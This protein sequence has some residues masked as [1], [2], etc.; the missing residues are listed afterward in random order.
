MK[1]ELNDG[2]RW[3]SEAETEKNKQFLFFLIFFFRFSPRPS[4]FLF[5][6][7]S[8]CFYFFPLFF[9]PRSAPEATPPPRARPKKE[10]K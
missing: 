1:F 5:N 9:L 4:I 7:S 3:I 10:R 8:F 6:F 2:A